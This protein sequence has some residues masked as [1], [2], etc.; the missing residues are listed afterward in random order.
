[1]LNV[2][3]AGRITIMKLS[4]P[5]IDHEVLERAAYLQ[6][7]AINRY[8]VPQLEGAEIESIQLPVLLDSPAVYFY[9]DTTAAIGVIC[10]ANAKQIGQKAV[11]YIH[12]RGKD[13]T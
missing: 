1:M 12:E 4:W 2:N 6:K 7:M 10:R 9:N 3:D 8:T 5:D 13:V 11:R